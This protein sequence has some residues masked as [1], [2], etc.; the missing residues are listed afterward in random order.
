MEVV[1]LSNFDEV[2]IDKTV[3]TLPTIPG[4]LLSIRSQP[5]YFSAQ[6]SKED[7]AWIEVEASGRLVITPVSHSSLDRA[8][9]GQEEV[10][11]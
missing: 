3:S 1:S 4:T 10:Y 5:P 9:Y 11:H 6:Q 2:S 7:V 8:H